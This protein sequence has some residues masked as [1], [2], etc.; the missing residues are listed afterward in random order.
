MADC[1]HR[2]GGELDY[3]PFPNDEGRNTRQARLEVPVFARVLGIHPGSRILEVGCGR[4]IAL[5]VISRL[6]APDRLVGIDIDE[7]LLGA[8]AAHTHGLGVELVRADVRA[9]PFPDGSFDV[10]IDFGTCYHIGDPAQ[11]MTE[12]ARVLIAGG[13]FCHETPLSQ[14]LSHPIRWG[15]R[16]LPWE[17]APELTGGRRALMW[18]SRHRQP[19]PRRHPPKTHRR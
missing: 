9:L 7:S 5:P 4:G 2:L 16:R 13:L 15:G 10:V 3:R 12:I 14:L 8:A 11:A 18:S 6:C 17:S 19:H 1:R